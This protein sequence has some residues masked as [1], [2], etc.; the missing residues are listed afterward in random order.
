MK[1]DMKLLTEFL[2]LIRMNEVQQCL[3]KFTDKGL[4]VSVASPATS[5]MAKGLLYKEAFKDYQA[6]GNV[7]VDELEKVNKIFKTLGKEF[8]LKV[9]GNIMEVDATKKSVELELVDEKFIEQLDLDKEIPFDTEFKIDAK[10]LNEFLS[11]VKLTSD[12]LVIIETVE[13]GVKFY[14]TGKYKFNYNLNSEGTIKGTVVKFGEPFMQV[15]DNVSEG[16]LNFKVK[17]D[18]A[19]TANLKNDNYEIKFMVAPVVT[20]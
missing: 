13:G 9:K 2:K 16:E 10:V 4:E 19:L 7:G 1:V 6:I 5:H 12:S 8:L 20:D 15:F 14:N 11:D 18:T 17:T 3:L